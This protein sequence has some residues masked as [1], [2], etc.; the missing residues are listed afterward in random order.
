MRSP[1]QII[2][3]LTGMVSI[4][5]AIFFHE[6]STLL[7]A[8]NALMLLGYREPTNLTAGA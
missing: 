7:V 5:I 1:L 3:S 6:G 4:G 8:A 2:T